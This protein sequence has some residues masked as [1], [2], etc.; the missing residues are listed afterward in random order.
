M[1]GCMDA[2]WLLNF[3]CHPLNLHPVIS[4]SRLIVKTGSLNLF[5]FPIYINQCTKVFPI[6]KYLP[7]NSS[8][9]IAPKVQ[10]RSKYPCKKPLE[11]TTCS[12]VN[13]HKSLSLFSGNF[14]LC[15]K[16]VMEKLGS[17]QNSSVNDGFGFGYHIRSR[18]A[19]K[20]EAAFGL[21]LLKP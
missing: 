11:S 16:V 7:F 9:S 5:V 1:M 15:S 18:K 12:G 2:K 19:T 8:A 6:P 3:V 10:R 21:P 13:F 14:V 4:T 20:E 17:R